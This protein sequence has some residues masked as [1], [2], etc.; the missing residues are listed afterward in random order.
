MLRE[1]PNNNLLV[2]QELMAGREERA[3]LRAQVGVS[4]IERCQLFWN[5]ENKKDIF[6]ILL[7]GVPAAEGE[8]PARDEPSRL[9][10]TGE[11]SQG[12]DSNGFNFD[13]KCYN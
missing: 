13:L 12:E 10:S 9:G 2:S 3:D 4:Y 5:V 1:E 6:T 11:S 7:S 8:R